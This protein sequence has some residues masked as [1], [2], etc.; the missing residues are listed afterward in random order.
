MQT[1]KNLFIELSNLIFYLSLNEIENLPL[2]KYYDEYEAKEFNWNPFYLYQRPFSVNFLWKVEKEYNIIVYSSLNNELLRSILENSTINE[3]GIILSICNSDNND[4]KRIN[5]YFNESITQKNSVLLDYK[6]IVVAHNSGN[7]I[8]VI[9]YKGSPK[10]ATLL[11]LEKYLLE[12]A[13]YPDVSK[14]ISS[15]F[16]NKL[17][18]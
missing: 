17:R 10:E 14:V 12:L 15:D 16:N 1:N 2:I 18:H 3:F 7:W 13:K 9:K 8:P 11:Y 5:K 6:A 4:T